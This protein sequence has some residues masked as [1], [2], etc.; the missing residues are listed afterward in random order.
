MVTGYYAPSEDEMAAGGSDFPVLGEDEYLATITS[1]TTENKPNNY[2]SKGDE[3]PTHDMLRVK[4]DIT[5]FADGEPLVLEDGSDLEDRFEGKIP[6][7]VFLNPKKVGMVPVPAKTRK[8][9]AAAL[10][11]ALGQPIQISDFNALVGRTVIVSIKPENGYNNAK[12]FRA[13]KRARGRATTPKGPESA[14]TAVTRAA[15]VFDED[16]PANVSS[17]PVRDDDD[18]DF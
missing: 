17:N 2:P 6:G 5:S 1:I 8:F 10:G 4:Y 14:S 11:Q 3:A 15:Q 9:F 16:A 7:Q 13:A 18:L 12:D